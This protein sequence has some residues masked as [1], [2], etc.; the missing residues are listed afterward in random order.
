MAAVPATNQPRSIPIKQKSTAEMAREKELAAAEGIVLE[1]DFFCIS[2]IIYLIS[3][4]L[5]YDLFTY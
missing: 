3:M 2:Y 5:I 4:Y 1:S